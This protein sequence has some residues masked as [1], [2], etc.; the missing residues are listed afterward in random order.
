MKR[1]IYALL[2]TV[3]AGSAPASAQ[4]EDAGVASFLAADQ[5][6]DEVLGFPELRGFIQN[7]AARG[8]PQSARIQRFMA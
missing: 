1:L 4:F 6:G 5:D 2:A 3:L 8:A 7:M